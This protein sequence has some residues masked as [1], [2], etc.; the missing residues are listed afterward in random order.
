VT[1]TVAV[2]AANNAVCE[3]AQVSFHAEVTNGDAGTTY[4]WQVNG[5]N[6]GTNSPDFT[7]TTLQ[8]NDVV[9]CIVTTGGGCGVPNTGNA[10][11]AIINPKPVITLKPDEQILAGTTVNLNPTVTGNIVSYKWAPAVGLSDAN[12]QFPVASPE[13]TT[14]YTLTATTDQGCHADASV[15]VTVV[16]NVAIPNTFTPNADGYNDLWAIKYLDAYT[17]CTVNVYTRN[18]A[19]VYHSKGYN[20]AWNGTSGGKALPAGVYYYVIDLG[21]GSPLLSGNV[22]I[23]R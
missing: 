9:N 17:N 10:V 14:T 3:G 21:N 5:V 15:V 6:A 13:V 19:P 2:T 7:S 16:H 18:G 11:T 20:I 1:P 22:S 4:Q 8:N 12:S 23:I